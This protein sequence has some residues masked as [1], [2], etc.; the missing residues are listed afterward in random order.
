MVVMTI[1]MATSENKKD[2]SH[3]RT[4]CGWIGHANYKNVNDCESLTHFTKINVCRP[5]PNL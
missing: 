4:I 2:S 3:W 1:E 5:L